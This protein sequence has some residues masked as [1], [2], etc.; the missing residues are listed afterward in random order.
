MSIE[1]KAPFRWLEYLLALLLLLGT[2]AKSWFLLNLAQSPTPAADTS[3]TLLANFENWALQITPWFTPIL[4]GLL[5]LILLAGLRANRMQAMARPLEILLGLYFL[6]GALL[7]GLDPNAF[8]AQIRAYGVLDDPQAFGLTALITLSLECALGLAMLLGLRLFNLILLCVAA[9]LM[10]FTAL[11]AYAWSCEGLSDCGCLGG[12]KIAPPEA[13]AKNFI[14]LFMVVIIL[15]GKELKVAMPNSSGGEAAKLLLALLLA[16]AAFAYTYPQVFQHTPQQQSTTVPDESTAPTGKFATI[17][18]EAETGEPFDLSQGEYI[19]AMLSMTCDHCMATVPTLT[20]Y[21][22]NPDLPK[23]VALCLEPAP[24]DFDNF[25]AMTQAEFPMHNMGDSII[26]FGEFI[27]SA[28]PRISLV[29]DGVELHYWDDEA[30]SQEELLEVVA[31]ASTPATPSDADNPASTPATL[32]PEKV[33]KGLYTLFMEML[34]PPDG[35][36]AEQEY[37]AHMIE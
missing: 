21:T 6:W 4:A 20:E 26:T 9:L 28:P 23:L 15:R 22:L 12:V 24:G 32:A 7:K 14:M 35:P 16:G 25:K 31:T 10:G 17:Q 18:F 5:G 8:T 19:V 27:G 1:P 36:V 11:I 29:R 33:C 13:I 2:A 30:P 3:A 34:S 37:P